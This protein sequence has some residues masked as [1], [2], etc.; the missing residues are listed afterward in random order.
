MIE[1]RQR[2]LDAVREEMRV[3][4]YLYM[5]ALVEKAM[6]SDDVDAVRELTATM[7]QLTREVSGGKSPKRRGQPCG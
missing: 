2:E 4:C 3:A 7:R 6:K 1:A 5:N